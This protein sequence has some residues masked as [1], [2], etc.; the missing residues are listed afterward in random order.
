MNRI[1][2]SAI[3]I[4][5]CAIIGLIVGLSMNPAVRVVRG[6]QTVKVQDTTAPQ[7][8]DT[9]PD[10]LGGI[11]Y[12]EQ[13]QVVV[14]VTDEMEATREAY[15]DFVSKSPEQLGMTQAEYDATHEVLYEQYANALWPERN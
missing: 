8:S 11:V 12:G 10:M 5:I 1:T 13:E 6:Q 3:E 2:R 14:L 9:A 7:T 4:T 15:Y